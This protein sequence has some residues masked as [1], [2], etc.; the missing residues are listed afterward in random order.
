[1]S[2]IRAAIL[3]YNVVKLVVAFHS[4][5]IF[6]VEV[7]RVFIFLLHRLLF[8]HILSCHIWLL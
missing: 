8:L 2:M 1:M 3:V 7:T 6:Q 5:P 4:Y